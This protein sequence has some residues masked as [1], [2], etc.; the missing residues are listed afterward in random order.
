M[1]KYTTPPTLS[2]RTTRRR[3]KRKF[4]KGALFVLLL[5]LLVFITLASYAT[6]LYIKADSVI[7]ESYKSDGRDKSDLRGTQVDPRDD[8]VSILIIGVD[9][10]DS[11][12]NQKS[13]RSDT[14]MV[15]T[16]N[17]KDK[18]VKLLSI[19]RDSYVYIPKVDY[20]TKINHAHAFGGARATIDTVEELLDIPIDYYVKVN[21]EAFI[22]VVDAVDGIKVDVP[23]DFYEQDSKDKARAIHL[24]KGLQKL[25]GEEALALARTRKIDNDIE[26]GKRQQQVVKAVMSKAVSMN[27]IL[28]VDNI[29]E[30]VGKNMTTNMTFTEMKSFISYGTKGNLVI[31]PI[32]LEGEDYQPGDTYYWKI[33]DDSLDETIEILKEHLELNSDSD[34]DSNSDL[35]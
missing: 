22:E 12:E 27:S 9:S 35:N 24:R 18:S 7:S 28:K 17:I 30:A 14:L 8:N 20:K 23:F 2:G 25:D 16:L 11:R 4:R 33:D 1:S 26:R 13:A 29:M 15:A 21:F 6:Y 10:S 34:L 19:P 32:T 31:D 3:K 5:V